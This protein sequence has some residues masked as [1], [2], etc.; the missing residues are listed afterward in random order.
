MRYRLVTI[1]FLFSVVVSQQ[2]KGQI[3][4]MPLGNSIT[5]DNNVGDTRPE[6]DATRVAYRQKLYELLDQAGYNFEFVGSENAGEPNVPD[7]DNAGFPGIK[8]IELEELLETG[9]INQVNPFN[10]SYN[11]GDAV[12]TGPYL[13][14]FNPDVILLHIGTNDVANTTS[15]HIANILDEI[16]AY[17]NRVGKTVPVFLALIIRVTPNDPA[18]QTLN[19]AVET[20]AQTRITNG[21]AIEIVNME[22]GAGIVYAIDPAG[23][24]LDGLHPNTTGYDK[25]GTLWYNHIN[26]YYTLPSITSSGGTQAYISQLY[27]YQVVIDADPEATFSLVNPPSGMTIDSNTGLVSWTPA[28]NQTGDFSIEILAESSIGSDTETYTLNVSNSSLCITDIVNYWKFDE[29]TPGSYFDI[30]EENALCATCP[31]SATGTIGNAQLFDLN[32]EINVPNQG[33]WNWG[34]DDSFTLEVWM[35]T[36]SSTSGNR[37]IVGRERSTSFPN[38]HFWLGLDDSGT[39]RFVLFDNDDNFGDVGEGVG[40]ALN[41]GNWHHLVAVRDGAANKNQL[42]VDGALV[43]ETTIDYTANF[44]S[45]VALNIG[46]LSSS[47]HYEGLADELIIYNRNLSTTE[48]GEH[49]QAGL[50]GNEYCDIPP[51]INSTP[52]TTI[53][54]G[55]EYNYN[56]NA[57]AIPFPTYSLTTSPT[58]MTI[59]SQSGL[60]SWTPTLGQ[61]GPNAVTVRANN[62][63]GNSDQ[64]FT[65]NVAELPDCFTGLEHYWKFEDNGSNSFFDSFGDTD[66]TCANCPSTTTGVI[67]QGRTF[68]LNTE[69]SVNDNPSFD[70]DTDDD[71]TVELW[72]NTSGSTAGNRVLIGRDDSS[73]DLHFWVGL[74]SNGNARFT[75][76][77]NNGQGVSLGEGLGNALNDGNWHHIVAVRDDVIG[78]NLLYIDGVLVEEISINYL[79]NFA[80]SVPLDLGW[81]NLGAGFHYEG[82]LDEVAIYNR[83][84]TTIDVSGH[85]NAGMA[86]NDYC[87][88]T[89]TIATTSIPVASVDELYNPTIFSK[90]VPF[91]TFSLLQNPTG[92]TINAASGQISWTPNVTQIGMHNVEVQVTNTEGNDT[93]LFQVTVG[94]FNSPPGFTIGANQ[95]VNEDSGPTTVSNWATDIDDGDSDEVQNL[96]FNVVN[97]TNTSLFSSQPTINANG[98]LSFTPAGNS[99]GTATV[100]ITL[101]DNGSN[102]SPNNNTSEEQ[103]FTI[104]VTAL[105]DAPTFV[106][107]ANQVVNEDAGQQVIANWATSLSDGDPELVQNLTFQVLNTNPSLFSEVPAISTSGE[108]RYTPRSDAFGDAVLTVTLMDNGSQNG[109][110]DNSS[111]PVEV[112]ITVNPVND[113]PTMNEIIDPQ[114]IFLGSGEQSISFSG[115]TSGPNENQD[116]IITASANNTDIITLVDIDYTSPN[117]IGTLRFTPSDQNFG[118]AE[119]TVTVIDNGSSTSPSINTFSQTFTV[120]VEESNRPPSFVPGDNIIVDEDAGVVTIPNWATSIDDGEPGVTQNLTFNIISNNNPALLN[121]APV[122]N[123]PNGNLVFETM[124]DANGEALITIELEDEGGAKSDQISFSIVVNAVNDRPTFVVGPDQSVAPGSGLQRLESWASNIDDG[125]PELNQ[126][127]SFDIISNSNP[128]IFAQQP[129][130]NAIGDLTYIPSDATSGIA[131]LTLVLRDDGSSEGDNLNESGQVVFRIE[132]EGPTAIKD[133]I[134]ESKLKLFPNPI[135]DGTLTIAMDNIESGDYELFV[136]DL[137]GKIHKHSSGIITRKEVT[138]K[139]HVHKLIKGAYLIKVITE[140]GIYYEQFLKY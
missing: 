19:T 123:V 70:W 55:Q 92:M 137:M 101:S 7:G 37:V 63:N 43:E 71:F 117:T 133:K 98:D 44:E 89:P 51:A 103:S 56:V 112:N 59:D 64:S 18:T 113:P 17:E 14:A 57:I 23:D 107:G 62:A 49:Y 11:M 136:Y 116:L 42:F 33:S 79:G 2:L 129:S 125:D 124:D 130:V 31:T 76:F 115:V 5:Y 78:K 108:L 126:A 73:S 58:G 102:V 86:G 91:P 80:S 67:G 20:M 95:T 90:G 24:M 109:L 66:A 46:H 22:T 122:I 10:S 74:D 81:L 87:G 38:L 138:F 30:N 118:V 68:N 135:L 61:E 134:Q 139:L 82:A 110:N 99:N 127:L 4:I 41:D 75:L 105:N 97:N 88:F 32:S 1:F 119:I 121:G 132:V 100:T 15:T 13:D 104:Q 9:L 65:V 85:Y 47:F 128:A 111:A 69:V 72:F 54:V 35:N 52:L 36:S 96:T 50:L 94:N 12:T 3:K 28:T 25:M 77:N 140:S 84:L 29:T 83:A 93:Q 27:Q 26:S 8:A 16:D 120:T 48:I 53:T 60:I 40:A 34:K 39:A 45:D 106:A 6:N 114:P 131:D 21:D